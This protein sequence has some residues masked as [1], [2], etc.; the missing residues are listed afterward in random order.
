METQQPPIDQKIEAPNKDD[1]EYIARKMIAAEALAKEITGKELDWSMS[2][3]V[4]IQEILDSNKI[5]ANETYELQ[6]LGIAFGKIFVGNNEGYDWWMAEDQYGRDPCVRYK[7]TTM[8]IFPQ[9]MISKRIE[10]GEHVNVQELYDDLLETLDSVKK[11][12][13]PNTD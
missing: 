8:L 5:K 6:S 11:E 13:Y 7:E 9:T 10:D 12:Y 4:I 2:D 3:I 1:M